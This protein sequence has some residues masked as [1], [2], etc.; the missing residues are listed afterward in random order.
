M[1][2]FAYSLASTERSWARVAGIQPATSPPTNA[3]SFRPGWLEYR[4]LLMFKLHGRPGSATWMGDG[5]TTALTVEGLHGVD[6]MGAVVF[7]S[8]CYLPESPFLGALLGAG[9]SAVI[10]GSGVNY[11][12]VGT[13]AGADILGLY[14]RNALERGLSP[15][16]AL[17]WAKI[18]LTLKWRTAAV[19]DTLGFE[20]YTPNGGSIT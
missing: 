6:L 7:A 4:D 11:G 1:R 19:A 13:M 18:R 16:A 10:G 17:S 9:A 15:S 12:G 2:V 3:L 20:L 5:F 14:V 8:N